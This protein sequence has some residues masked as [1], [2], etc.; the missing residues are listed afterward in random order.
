MAEPL[1]LASESNMWSSTFPTF[2]IWSGCVGAMGCD[3]CGPAQFPHSVF[4][5]PYCLDQINWKGSAPAAC[6]LILNH[7]YI[8]HYLLLS[9]GPGPKPAQARP[10]PGPSPAQALGFQ[11]RETL[12][13]HEILEHPCC[14]CFAPAEFEKCNRVR[15]K[16]PRVLNR[17]RHTHS[18]VL[19]TP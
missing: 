13:E 1:G 18:I 14:R 2:C 10:K 3:V 7:I 12:I 9:P 11:A 6:G 15:V 19:I 5:L 8:Y 4:G 17:S 16:R